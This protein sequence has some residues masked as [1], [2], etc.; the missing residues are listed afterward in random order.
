[1][2]LFAGACSQLREAY[3]YLVGI[4]SNTTSAEYYEIMVLRREVENLIEPFEIVLERHFNVGYLNLLLL[5]LSVT[6][7]IIGRPE[8]GIPFVVNIGVSAYLVWSMMRLREDSLYLIAVGTPLVE[9]Y[10]EIE[11][12]N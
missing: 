12:K 10:R 8:A 3:L 11:N 4:I 6:L 2:I 9:K 7:R 5:L 1:M